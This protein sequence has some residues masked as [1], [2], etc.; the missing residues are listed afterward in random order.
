MRLG[1]RPRAS[2]AVHTARR[3]PSIERIDRSPIFSKQNSGTIAELPKHRI[4]SADDAKVAGLDFQ[5]L[6]FILGILGGAS[7]TLLWEVFLQPFFGRRAIAEVLAAEVSMNLQSLAAAETMATNDQLAA[8]FSLSTKVFESVIDR[9]GYLT[10]RLVAETVFLYR[11]FFDLNDYPKAYVATIKELR[12]YAHGSPNYL[13]CERELLAEIKVFNY[14]V[15][16][17]IKRI[18]LVQPLL[19][20]EAFPWWTPRRRTR[21]VEKALDVAELRQTIAR[22]RRERDAQAADRGRD[23]EYH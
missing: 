15:G 12:G 18:E 8:D 4:I 1:A 20:K 23:V 3:T 5:T 21:P 19:L 2:P 7:A 9:V 10:P 13:A 6:E 16:K 17:A 11:Y 22:S 14:S